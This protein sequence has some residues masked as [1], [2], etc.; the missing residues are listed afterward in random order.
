MGGMRDYKE[1]HSA[2]I[3]HSLTTVIVKGFVKQQRLFLIEIIVGTRAR[4]IPLVSFEKPHDSKLDPLLQKLQAY[5]DGQKVDFSAIPIDLHG[6]SSF[7]SAVL[8]TARR[9][10]FGSTY[11][12]SLLAKEAGFPRA[13]R[14]TASVMRKNPLP[15]IIPCHRVI[16]KNGSIGSYCGDE[17]GEDAALKQ[18]LLQLERARKGC[19]R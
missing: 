11:S 18:R 15:L 17:H 1:I 19:C 2:I 10:P 12:Y 4:R 8:Q 16:Q 6:F 14:A 5:L 9:I 3:R 13:I 7:Q